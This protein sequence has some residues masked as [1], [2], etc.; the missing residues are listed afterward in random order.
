MLL[1]CLWIICTCIILPAR[2]PNWHWKHAK[3]IISVLLCEIRVCVPFCLLRSHSPAPRWS[4]PPAP[5]LGAWVVW[6]EL[7]VSSAKLERGHSFLKLPQLS[8]GPLGPQPVP[9][10]S[11]LQPHSPSLI[12]TSNP[13][14]K[15][16]TNPFSWEIRVFQNRVTKSD[17][18]QL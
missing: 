13:G 11:P 4:A 10:P 16:Y 3:C 5:P 12:S 2:K 17:H 8:S 14:G 1:F 9:A 7:A 15:I 18:S 6:G